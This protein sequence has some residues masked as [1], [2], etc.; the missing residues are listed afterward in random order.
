[1]WS[2]YV[3]LSLVLLSSFSA[4]ANDV[5]DSTNLKLE[6]GDRVLLHGAGGYVRVIFDISIWDNGRNL[7]Y[8]WQAKHPSFG[9]GLLG[10]T[11]SEMGTFGEVS[12]FKKFKKID[13]SPYANI[14]DIISFHPRKFADGRYQ[15]LDTVLQGRVTE[16]FSGDHF[17]LKTGCWTYTAI[18]YDQI[19]RD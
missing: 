16:L 14:G 12:L 2:K 11:I 7:E 3:V 19:A 10:D 17:L 8:K 4:T 13:Q 1:M 15:I 18:Q 6:V 5:V 9:T